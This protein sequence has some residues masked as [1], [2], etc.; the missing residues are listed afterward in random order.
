MNTLLICL[1][2]GQ[3]A[4]VAALAWIGYKALDAWHVAESAN[5]ILIRHMEKNGLAMP[6]EEE[7]ADI[8]YEEADA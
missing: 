3:L 2:I 8:Y 1:T 5:R 4:C 7:V 6:T